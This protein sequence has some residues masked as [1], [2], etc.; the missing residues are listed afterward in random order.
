MT[1]QD[2]CMDGYEMI[3]ELMRLNIRAL[4][5]P[6]VHTAHAITTPKPVCENG[7]EA[8]TFHARSTTWLMVEDRE[9]CFFGS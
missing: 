6:D 8:S 1:V 2:L 4:E 9:G 7:M 5:P 3:K